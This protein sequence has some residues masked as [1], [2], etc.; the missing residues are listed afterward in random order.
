VSSIEAVVYVPCGE[1]TYVRQAL[2]SESVLLALNIVLRS[3]STFRKRK[4]EIF[5]LE[6]N[7]YN[8]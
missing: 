7:S 8:V 4:C 3:Y 5:N 2:L 1:N 6:N